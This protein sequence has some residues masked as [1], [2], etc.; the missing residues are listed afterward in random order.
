MS[1]FT[2]GPINNTM[3]FVI[4]ISCDAISENI[5]NTQTAERGSTQIN[6]GVTELQAAWTSNLPAHI[7]STLPADGGPN[8]GQT[9]MEILK[10]VKN[11][12]YS[13]HSYIKAYLDTTNPEKVNRFSLAFITS[14]ITQI[15][16]SYS[17]PT[18]TSNC[19][20]DLAACNAMNTLISST[21]TDETQPEQ[22]TARTYSTMLQQDQSANT[23]LAGIGDL[24]N[25]CDSSLI[26]LISQ[27]M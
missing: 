16:D 23:Q 1:D 15:N 7:P 5:S 17:H 25:E 26:A 10:D 18:S 2:P 20:L 11:G 8:N 4:E 21:S 3:N 27:Q 12:T 24:A 13:I 19:S 6:N 22:T 14:V 9:Y